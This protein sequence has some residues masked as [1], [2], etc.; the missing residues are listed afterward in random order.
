[1][2]NLTNFSYTT[3]GNKY[4]ARIKN[5]FNGY[6]YLAVDKSGFVH[7]TGITLATELESVEEVLE[8]A[9]AYCH[10]IAYKK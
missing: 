7:K 2:A 9:A 1:M 6:S 4:I 5:G 8:V 10:G 3:L